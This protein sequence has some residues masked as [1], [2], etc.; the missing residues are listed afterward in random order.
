MKLILVSNRLPI[1]VVKQADTFI[2]EKSI[3]GLA[4]TFDSY[5]KNND[6]TMHW[7]GWPGIIEDNGK[8]LKQKRLNE[9]NGL[10][11]IFLSEKELKG[12]Y[13]GFC[14]Q[15]IWP[16]FHYF[17][18][19]CNVNE[20]YWELY[21]QVNYKFADNVIDLYEDGDFIFIQD[22]HLMLLPNILRQKIDNARIG[23]FLHIPFPNYEIFRILPINWRTHILRGLLGADLIGFHTEDYM[24]YFL[25]AIRRMM[26]IAS[27]NNIIFVNNRM[28]GA[29]TIP[30]GIDYDA[31]SSNHS[32]K[33][34]GSAISEFDKSIQERK[35][36][37]SVDRLDY[38]KGIL[39]RL[40]TYGNFLSNYPEYKRKVTMLV[41]AAPSR[42]DIGRY[43]F[44]NKQVNELVG[45]INGKFGDIDWMP[46]IY[47]NKAYSQEELKVLYKRADVALVTPLRD[48]MNLIAKEYVASRTDGTGVLILSEF[49]GAVKELNEAIIVN[50]HSKKE[51]S[52]ALKEA[53]E[54]PL[55]EQ[56]QRNR[57]M[58]KKIKANGIEKWFEFFY[59]KGTNMSQ[60]QQSQKNLLT[61]KAAYQKVF[62]A[63]SRSKKG[64]IF[65]D[66]DGT[67]MEFK[68]TPPEAKPTK[69]IV[70]LLA[71][72]SADQKNVVVLVSG[73][74][75]D[76]M[77]EWF[78]NLDIELVAEHGMYARKERVWKLADS[79]GSQWK[80]EVKIIMQKYKEIVEGTFIEE[81]D[82]ALAW[83]Y[84]KADPKQTKRHSTELIGELSVL[85]EHK[86]LQVLRG[87]KVIEVKNSGMNKGG[88][89]DQL[90]TETRPDFV[91]CIGDDITDEDMFVKLP[92]NA[93]SIKVG[94]NPSLANYRLKDP[95][96]VCRFLQFLSQVN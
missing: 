48:G 92:K 34:T 52:A 29:E 42:K 1:N 8:K 50:P 38:T 59:Q 55:S 75:K 65:L 61:D 32:F 53:L 87:S 28:V 86:D 51:C 81:K 46:I 3:G 56:K 22:Y 84:R 20:N 14:N 71:K 23:F 88:A 18:S 30:L 17:P 95:K 31:F 73:R 35:I 15:V 44:M 36:I 91:L 16:L 2:F 57:I 72:L 67:L 49:A 33:K 89:V 69:E 58:Q 47:Q 79:L 77:E 10:Y 19:Y 40:Q 21:K 62:A 90:I 4:T 9:E 13:E 85:T 12:Y 66:Y 26:G 80:K 24:R 68:P 43:K 27:K 70:N 45:K 96:E 76:S 54:M 74:D 83:H 82:F 11:P 37:L 63:L 6:S 78:G 25:D 64:L 41:I 7:V 5:A 60:R 94:T 93:V 39:N